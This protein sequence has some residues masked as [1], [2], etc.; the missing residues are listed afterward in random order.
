MDIQPG[1]R[2]TLQQLLHVLNEELSTQAASGQL[3]SD[4]NQ[5]RFSLNCSALTLPS[6]HLISSFAV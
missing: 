3:A 4:L 5:V 1:H 2:S 6:S